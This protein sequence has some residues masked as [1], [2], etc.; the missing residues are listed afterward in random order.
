MP[1]IP[2]AKLTDLLRGTVDL[3]VNSRLITWLPTPVQCAA[4]YVFLNEGIVFVS[5]IV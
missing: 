1:G 5:E 2:K 3:T 4:W